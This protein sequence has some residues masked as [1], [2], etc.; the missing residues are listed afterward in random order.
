MNWDWI[1]A[2]VI[3]VGLVLAIW[4]RISHQSIPE[5][6]SGLRDFFVETKEGVEERAED[7]ISYE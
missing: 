3:I 2:V 7:V 6:L 1:I 4:A 5:L